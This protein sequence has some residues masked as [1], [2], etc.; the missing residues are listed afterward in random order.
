MPEKLI[1]YSFGAVEGRI[2]SVRGQKVILD[3]VLAALYGVPTFRFNEAVKRNRERF[4]NDFSFQLNQEE[5]SVLIS[6]FA[7]SKPGRGGTRKLPWVFTEHGAIQAAN[8][9]NSKQAVRMGV[10][11]V[12]AFVR[13][14]EALTLHKDLARKL[15]ALEKKVGAQ[16]ARIQEVFD[17]LRQLMKPP[18]KP[19]RRIGFTAEEKKAIY[20][21]KG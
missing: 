21:A 1:E 20:Q 6:Q 12:R 3:R 8:I 2:F 19:K 7:I 15:E 10:F 5:F 11:V 13:L 14:R 16:D 17:A 9:L 18:D 4:P